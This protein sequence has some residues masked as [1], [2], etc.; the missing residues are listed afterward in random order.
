MKLDHHESPIADHLEEPASWMSGRD[1]A[2]GRFATLMR[3]PGVLIRRLQQIQSAIFLEETIAFG[4]TPLQF[5]LMTLLVDHPGIEQGA[6]ATKLQLDRFTAAGVVRRLEAAKYLRT[7]QGQDRRA[8]TLYL[9][10]RGLKTF[11]KLYEQ[12][13]RAHDRLI[14][15]FTPE[16][17]RLFMEMLFE[18]TERHGSIEGSSTIR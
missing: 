12:A 1:A 14:E 5:S 8:K 13:M 6:A 2:D 16:R 11:D 18:L 17:R 10:T 15:P 7:K 3:R 9:T 4:V